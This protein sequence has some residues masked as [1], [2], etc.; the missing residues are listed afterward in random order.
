MISPIS[1]LEVNAWRPQNEVMRDWHGSWLAGENPDMALGR[2][3]QV[4]E[5]KGARRNARAI[6]LQRTRFRANRNKSP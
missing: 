1:R 5:G 3:E 2:R 4:G 6:A